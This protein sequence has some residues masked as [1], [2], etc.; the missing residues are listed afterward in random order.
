GRHWATASALADDL[1]RAHGLS[2]RAAH[3]VV[4]RFVAAHEAAGEPDGTVWPDL[5]EGPLREY[6]AARLAELLDPRAFVESR[7]SP[8]G[9]AQPVGGL[10]VG[11][12]V[13]AIVGLWI[14]LLT[15]ASV[16]LAL[17]VADLDPAG[18]ASSLALVTGVGAIFA[19][20]SNPVFGRLSDLCTSRWG[21]RR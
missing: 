4:A 11:L 5:A 2:F 20:V 3:D 13:L 18:K 21:R 10:F 8:G 16:T 1:V 9:T 7:A 6:S 17:R 14:A 12:Y 15:P 19:M